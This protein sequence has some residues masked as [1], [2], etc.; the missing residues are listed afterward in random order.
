MSIW[1]NLKCSVLLSKSEYRK[2]QAIWSLAL[3]TLNSNIWKHSL[4]STLLCQTPCHTGVSLSEH[5]LYYA[6]PDPSVPPSILIS[7]DRWK[8]FSNEELLVLFSV[9][10]ELKELYFRYTVLT[11]MIFNCYFQFIIFVNLYSH[12]LSVLKLKLSLHLQNVT[13]W[14][15]SVKQG[16]DT[17]PCDLIY[18]YLLCLPEI[19]VH[20]YG[21]CHHL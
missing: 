10:T 17:P 5:R 14:A 2:W 16:V 13:I 20:R 7:Y 6:D 15:K 19:Y 21:I 12:V 3:V 18:S 1:Y 4:V 8:N 11:L 9:Y